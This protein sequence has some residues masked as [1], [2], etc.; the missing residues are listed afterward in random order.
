VL[1]FYTD[2]THTSKLILNLS[3]GN[4]KLYAIRRQPDSIEV[5]QMKVKAKERQTIRDAERIIPNITIEKF[6]FK[7]PN[8]HNDQI[9]PLSDRC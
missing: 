3:T 4:H 1:V 2:S 6:E 5:Q 8:G 7:N 9:W